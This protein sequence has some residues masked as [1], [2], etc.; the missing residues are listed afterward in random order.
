[1]NDHVRKKEN[2]NKL[3]LLDVG[4]GNGDRRASIDPA[5]IYC[6]LD[7]ENNAG[8]SVDEFVMGDI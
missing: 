1:M 8:L 6:V 4:G 7:I 5:Y 2:R 3:R